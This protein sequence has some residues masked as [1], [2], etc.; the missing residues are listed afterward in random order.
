M[1]IPTGSAAGTS[2]G[3]RRYGT[4]TATHPQIE[5][6]GAQSPIRRD[7]AQKWPR[8][9]T[10]ERPIAT[11]STITV[12]RPQALAAGPA[13]EAPPRARRRRAT[14]PRGR[15]EARAARVDERVGGAAARSTSPEDYVISEIGGPDHERDR[16]RVGVVIGIRPIGT[17]ARTADARTMQ[18]SVR[19]GRERS[20]LDVAR[21]GER[22]PSPGISGA[23][24]SSGR[25]EGRPRRSRRPRSTA[26]S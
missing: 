10:R 17:G 14:V 1:S 11:A 24:V 16:L 22:P 21:Y 23:P 19:D 4:T 2:P 8:R 9:Y 12:S 7:V 13:C 3:L 25:P 20:H 6:T 5:K 18:T 26:A 15:R